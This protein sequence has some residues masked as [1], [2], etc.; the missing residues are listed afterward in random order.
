MRC[1]KNYIKFIF[2]DEWTNG[3]LYTLSRAK[4]NGTSF[5]FFSKIGG[6]DAFS[7]DP[8]TPHIFYATRFLYI[9]LK[10]W[11]QILLSHEKINLFCLN[12]FSLKWIIIFFYLWLN[13]PLITICL[14]NITND[15]GGC[16][17][18]HERSER[19]ESSFRTDLPC[20]GGYHLE[21]GATT[22]YL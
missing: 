18:M 7:V 4:S 17:S 3:I 16:A 14:G 6:G 21:R 22:E 8:P 13:D 1:S 19:V 9:V 15:C 11:L 5:C 20:S 2:E 12:H 10:I